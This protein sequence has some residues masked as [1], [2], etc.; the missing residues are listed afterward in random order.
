[1][2]IL[3][4]IALLVGGA[5]VAGFSEGDSARFAA[6]VA[7]VLTLVVA[8]AGWA[9]AGDLAVTVPW[10]TSWDISLH[11]VSGGPTWAL[12]GLAAVVGLSAV[13][14]SWTEINERVGLFHA[15]LLLAT[16]AAAGTFVAEDLLT[17]FLFF[18]GMLI[19]AWVLVAVYG[20]GNAKAAATRFFLFTQAGGLLMFL[21][22]LGFGALFFQENGFWS[23]QI[24]D[25]APV[26]A[27][28]PVGFWLMVGL[29]IGLAVKLP[30]IPLHGWLA[31]T[32]ASAPTGVTIL[33]SALLSKAGAWG[34]VHF[35]PALFKGD[36]EWF[37]HVM[38][39]LAA[40]GVVYASIYAWT[41]RDLKRVIAWM[42]IA[43]LGLIPI[44]VFGGL[45]VGDAGVV[46]LMV[47]HGLS[48]AAMFAVCGM[49]EA[50]T[51]SR[52][53]ADVHGLWHVTPKLA[54][55]GLLFTFASV[56]VPGFGNFIGEL[57]ILLGGFRENPGPTVIAATGVLG[58]TLYGMS[59]FA[60][61]FTGE[62]PAKRNLPDLDAREI[63]LL[64]GLALLL[65]IIG[66]YPSVLLDTLGPD[67]TAALVETAP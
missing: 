8:L 34:M 48:S 31:D 10:L 53:F 9:G 26:A 61:T 14:A 50:R 12:V 36:N 62:A 46:V 47:A 37:G 17:F 56:G 11:F 22:I 23:F 41:Q 55:G 32:Y 67:A 13:A 16:A 38:A 29:F 33:F 6:V 40:T 28:S 58:G 64:A 65:L 35:L 15:C 1:M 44:G 20:K 19:P 21:A 57:L 51:G 30:L 7:L 39:W 42:S 54:F 66:F 5:V 45:N 18:E 43:H 25:V 63:T 24:A 2:M 27:L 3:G 49:V 52:N 4:A 60:R 59:W